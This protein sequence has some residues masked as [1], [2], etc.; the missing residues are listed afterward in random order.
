MIEEQ[1]VVI[2]II[3]HVNYQEIINQIYIMKK[4]E[5]KNEEELYIKIQKKNGELKIY[6]CEKHLEI[7]IKNMYQENLIY[8][9]IKINI[10]NFLFRHAMGYGML[11]KI[12][13]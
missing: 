13:K 3:R 7:L 4:K 9:H 10:L 11:C 1:L 6:L 5:L 12:K 8:T 2:I